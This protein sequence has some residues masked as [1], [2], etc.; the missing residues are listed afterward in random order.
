MRKLT[1]LVLAV[2][3]VLL[4]GC[5]VIAA[6][7]PASS[8]TV[9]PTHPA[10]TSVPSK[11]TRPTATET[12]TPTGVPTRVAFSRSRLGT[13]ERDILYCTDGGVQLHLDMYYPQE[14]S[15]PA[16][17]IVYLHGGSWSAGSKSDGVGLTEA[18][19]LLSRG[20][21]VTSIDYRH[22]PEWKFPAQIQ[23]AKCAIRFLRANAARF[24][25]D[26]AHIGALGHS[27]GGHTIAPLGMAS[28]PSAWG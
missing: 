17:G 28:V 5:A 18:H 16:P 13:V 15:K 27:A 11:T 2:L 21:L 24:N 20:Y 4:A 9:A 3:V 26:P 12:V 19:E 23:D 22:A 1:S 8:P 10:P 6:S 14:M 7:A 25:L